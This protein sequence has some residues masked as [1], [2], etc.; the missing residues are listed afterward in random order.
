MQGYS[1]VHLL[2]DFSISK[3][4]LELFMQDDYHKTHLPILVNSQDLYFF[5]SLSFLWRWDLINCD[6]SFRGITSCQY[7]QNVDIRLFSRFIQDRYRYKGIHGFWP[8][9]RGA[10]WRKKKDLMCCV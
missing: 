4:R 5:L 7:V 6:R 1:F 9:E 2:Q 10:V 3:I 8:Q